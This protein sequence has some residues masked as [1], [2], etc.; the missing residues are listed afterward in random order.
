M[1]HCNTDIGVAAESQNVRRC[2][3]YFTALRPGSI[4]ETR[5]SVIPGN[6]AASNP[7]KGTPMKLPSLIQKSVPSSPVS[8]LVM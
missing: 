8:V 2:E 1:P 6:C 5:K 4:Q 3:A 7:I